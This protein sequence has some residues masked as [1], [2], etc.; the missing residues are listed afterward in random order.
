M[1]YYDIIMLLY[2]LLTLII[3]WLLLSKVNEELLI[4]ILDYW[5][6]M[7][8]KCIHNVYDINKL[9]DFL[10]FQKYKNNDII[11]NCNI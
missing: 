6:P 7:D 5:Y 10:F 3:I 11:I 9:K 8:N 4:K 2:L 1:Y